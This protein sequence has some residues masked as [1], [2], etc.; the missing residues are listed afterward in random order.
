MGYSGFYWASLRVTGF[1]RVFSGFEWIAM[2]F[3]EFDWVSWS[4]I[5]F[6]CGS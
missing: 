6:Y 4:F 5:R 3:T 1:N 2:D